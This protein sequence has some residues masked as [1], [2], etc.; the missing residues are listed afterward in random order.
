MNTNGEGQVGTRPVRARVYRN[1]GGSL[2]FLVT[3]DEGL[4][5]LPYPEGRYEWMTDEFDLRVYVKPFEHEE[6]PL[7]REH[8]QFGVGA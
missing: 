1:K 4:I 2:A 8:A 5:R 3:A 7:C 6:H